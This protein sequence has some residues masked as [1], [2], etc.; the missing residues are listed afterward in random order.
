MS[1]AATVSSPRILLLPGRQDSG[2][3]Q[4]IAG[5]D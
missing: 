5:V 2:P 4:L 3:A 1:A